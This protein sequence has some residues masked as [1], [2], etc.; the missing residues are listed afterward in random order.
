MSIT[1]HNQRNETNSN[2]YST[3]TLILIS[4]NPIPTFDS[5]HNAPPVLFFLHQANVRNEVPKKGDCLSEANSS[6]FRGTKKESRRKNIAL[7]FSFSIF[8]FASRLKK[9]TCQHK[10][11]HNI[12]NYFG[13]FK[14][15][16]Y[17]KNVLY[18]HY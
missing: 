9:S 2:K 1:T 14:H 3:K 6:P 10:R 7:I 8:S 11:L 18:L 17:K 4:V 12:L 5:S 16:I 13:S 15:I